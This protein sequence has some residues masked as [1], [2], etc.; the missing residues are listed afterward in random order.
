MQLKQIVKSQCKWSQKYGAPPRNLSIKV[1]YY[2][3]T[4]RKIS[5]WF[6]PQ[7]RDYQVMPSDLEA[8]EDKNG[9]IPDDIILL[10]FFD[11]GKRWPDKLTYLGTDTNDTSLLHFPGKL[12]YTITSFFFFLCS[13]RVLPVS[14]PNF[15][16]G[17]YHTPPF[18]AVHALFFILHNSPIFCFI[19]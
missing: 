18:L 6:V 9:K 11:W 8:W 14:T 3:H 1:P 16:L 19:F 15:G 4:R 7:N 17:W 10:L 13:L 12:I 5:R 2:S